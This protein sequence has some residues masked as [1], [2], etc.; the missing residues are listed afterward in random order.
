MNRLFF[1][2]IKVFV[3]KQK[4]LTF[5]PSDKE[6]SEAHV[7]ARKQAIIGICFSAIQKLPPEQLP[8]QDLLLLW[9]L[10][11]G[12]IEEQS[13][14]LNTRSEEAMIFFKNAGFHPTLLKGQGMASLYPE[15]LRRNGG[16]IDIWVDGG[17]KRIYDFARKYDKNGKLYGVNYHHVHLHLFDD[18]DVELHIYPARLNNPFKNKKLHAFF[19]EYSSVKMGDVPIFDFNLIFILLHCFNHF[20][21]HGIGIKQFMDYYFL[22]KSRKVKNE[23]LIEKSEKKIAEL[24]L[25]RFARGTMWLMQELFGLEDEYL[26]CKPDEEEGRFILEEIMLTG[27]MGHYDKR[28]WGSLKT[29][30]S[31]FFYNMRRDLY[32]LNHY[33]G[34]VIWQPFFSLYV[35]FHRKLIWK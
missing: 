16:D 34:T 4:K 17:R 28:N 26:I 25:H 11:T 18:A 2:I 22:L 31:R 6:W 14:I 12:Q 29:P 27:N 20:V 10:E 23:G 19:E 33:F 1:E 21:G 9:Y 8:D 3:G 5:V 30:L 15:P 13:K 32:F 7:L 35:Y 24:G